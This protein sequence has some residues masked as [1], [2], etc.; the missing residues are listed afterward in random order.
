MELNLYAASIHPSVPSKTCTPSTELHWH[1]R[2]HVELVLYANAES[3]RAVH[4]YLYADK[5]HASRVG[6]ALALPLAGRDEGYTRLKPCWMLAAS[7]RHL[8]RLRLP[9]NT[10][11]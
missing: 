6:H 7:R 4:L 5:V 11:C 2:L 8:G 1:A 9:A 10:A 3:R